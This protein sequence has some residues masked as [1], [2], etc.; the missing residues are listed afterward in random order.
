MK[1]KYIPEPTN[2]NT[3]INKRPVIDLTSV[4][5]LKY[6]A[7]FPNSNCTKSFSMGLDTCIAKLVFYKFPQELPGLQAL[8]FVVTLVMFLQ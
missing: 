3:A 2:R 7:I 1:K 6:F 4:L 5:V 8:L